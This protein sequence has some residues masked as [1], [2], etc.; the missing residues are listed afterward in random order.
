MDFVNAIKSGVRP[1]FLISLLV[2]LVIL[3]LIN[4]FLP[5]NYKISKLIGGLFS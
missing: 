5:A 3:A 2:A 4:G 1:N